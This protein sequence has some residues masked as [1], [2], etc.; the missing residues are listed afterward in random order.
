ME[1]IFIVIDEE[2]EE[3]EN[4]YKISNEDTLNFGIVTSGG[5]RREGMLEKIISGLYTIKRISEKAEGKEMNFCPKCGGRPKLRLGYDTEYVECTKCGFSTEV[6][7]GDYYDEGFMNGDM[8]IPIWNN[9]KADE[10]NE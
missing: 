8:A 6:C 4:H 5:R 2:G 3:F 7:V 1:E 9:I 10:V